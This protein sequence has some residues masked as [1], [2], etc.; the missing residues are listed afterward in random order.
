MDTND[1]TRLASRLRSQVAALAR[2]LRQEAHSDVIPFSQVAILGAIDRL[3]GTV[4]PSELAAAEHLR[5]S[6]LAAIL[7]ALETEGQID[8]R[9]DRDDGR[10]I[11]VSLTAQGKRTLYGTRTRREEWL[12][13]AMQSCLT[14]DERTLLTDA[15][16][17]LERLVQ[18]TEAPDDAPP[19]SS[20]R[21]SR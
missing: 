1:I 3:G 20:R 15:S 2:R 17:L 9:V 14:A 18:Y 11:R 21:I 8:R 10:K 4:T 6:N 13:R 7:R 19:P 5:S 12:V 16:L